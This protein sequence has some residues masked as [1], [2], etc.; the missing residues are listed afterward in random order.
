[1]N[2]ALLFLEDIFL[3]NEKMVRPVLIRKPVSVWKNI[4][5]FIFNG[6]YTKV[7]L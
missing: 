5:S 3:G 2:L 4:G 7:L 6:K 1:V